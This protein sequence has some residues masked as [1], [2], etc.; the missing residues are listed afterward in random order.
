MLQI[1]MQSGREGP[2][3]AVYTMKGLYRVVS[4]DGAIAELPHTVV[5]VGI[6]EPWAGEPPAIPKLPAPTVDDFHSW[7]YE[8]LDELAQGDKWD[9]R[10]TLMQRASYD[11]IWK[12]LADSFC[13]HVNTC[14]GAALQHLRSGAPLPAS[15]KDFI[16]MLPVWEKPVME[17]EP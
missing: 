5:G 8:H 15:K 9:S 1:T 17:L 10:I 4:P 3:S 6:V 2:F 11:G 7:L 14:E 16:A 12:P 13:K